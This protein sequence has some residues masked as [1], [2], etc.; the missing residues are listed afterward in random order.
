[1]NFTRKSLRG[2]AVVLPQAA[3]E[4]GNMLIGHRGVVAAR[5]LR[6]LG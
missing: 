4:C 2:K 5:Q 1:M 6:L 3:N